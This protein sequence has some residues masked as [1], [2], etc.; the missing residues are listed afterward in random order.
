MSKIQQLIEDK[1]TQFDD[2]GYF[3][4]KIQWKNC[5][6]C[7]IKKPLRNNVCL[8]CQGKSR[9]SEPKFYHDNN[10][11]IHHDILQDDNYEI[12]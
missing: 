12:K 4:P 9:L 8:K 11:S 1:E 5:T 2:T 7:N 6:V 10:L 3:E